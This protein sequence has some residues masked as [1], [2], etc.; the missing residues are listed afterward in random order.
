MA[1]NSFLSSKALSNPSQK[2]SPE[3]RALVTD[4]SRVVEQA[5]LLLLSKNSANLTQDCMM[6]K[7]LPREL[8]FANKTTSS[9]LADKAI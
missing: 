5:K 7:S 6:T 9:L 1:L 8:A 4:F 3:G 2:L